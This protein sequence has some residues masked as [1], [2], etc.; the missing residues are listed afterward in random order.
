MNLD[1]EDYIETIE[2]GD[3]TYLDSMSID[4]TRTETDLDTIVNYS[5][6]KVLSTFDPR[7]TIL[8]GK[9]KVSYKTMQLSAHKIEVFWENDSLIA[10]G[11][12]DTVTLEAPVI[13][14]DSVRI[15]SL[16]IEIDTLM[17][18]NA[19]DLFS[20][21]I[22]SNGERFITRYLDSLGIKRHSMVV[23][24]SGVECYSMLYDSIRVYIYEI[25]LDSSDV[26]T[27]TVV[28]RGLPKMSDANQVIEGEKMFYNIKSRKGSVVEGDTKY[29]DGF[30]HGT[31][32][33]KVDED[34]LNI[35]SGYYTTCDLDHPHYHFWS[36]DLKLVVKNKV[37]ARPVVLHFGPV[38]V[39][40]IPFAIFPTRGGRQSGI[41]IPTYGESAS[42]GRYFRDLGYYWAPNDYMDVNGMLD[43][44]ERYGIKM[45]GS[46]RYV[47]RYI[48]NG[49]LTGSMINMR[50]D[51]RVTR[52]WGIR[53]SHKHILSPSASLNMSGEY[54]SDAS[55]QKDLSNNPYDRMKREMSSKATFTKSW[56]GTPYSGSVNISHNEQLTSG[57][58]TQWM[59]Q[60]S[61]SRQNLPIFPQAEDE[62]PDEARWYNR[63]YFKYG[64][65]GKLRKT[66]NSEKVRYTET[67]PTD[68]F[69]VTKY[70]KDPWRYKSGVQH[71][72]SFAGAQDVLEYFT[73]SPSFSY[74]EDWFDEWLEWQ[75]HEDDKIDSIKHEEFI[76]RR[77][78]SAS[79]GL[80]TTLYGLFKP[81]LF[82]IEAL[83]HKIDPSLSFSYSPDFSDPHWD[84]YDKFWDDSAH[85]DIKKDKFQGNLYGSTPS[86]ESMTLRMSVG[87]LFQYKRVKDEEE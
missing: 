7:I 87:N 81:G 26:G 38:P 6:E 17:T 8:T 67:T 34:V 82:G 70:Y 15:D 85:R 13:K 69:L 61:F 9:A 79:T 58:V 39:M 24:S 84:Y 25:M 44:Y 48:F 29:E 45:N 36:R 14:R 3:S 83:R 18:D 56:P 11:I 65:S 2:E 10:D 49:N 75:R 35:R 4:T 74:T 68:T 73:L 32:I 80:S 40:I 77:T 76:A 64:S 12:L 5:A 16:T 60:L 52:R 28:W 71:K 54:Q 30:C 53:G 43:F 27:D 50:Y 63:L 72:I 78:F 86:N 37:I 19:S 20:M 55:Y 22:E 59:P 46:S 31:T 41:I 66:V 21:M 23:D 42:Q 62:D 57:E 47:K 33:K 51:N 1:R